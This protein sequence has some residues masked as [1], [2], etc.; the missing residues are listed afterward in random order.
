M[1]PEPISTVYFINPSHQSVRLYVYPANVARQRLGKNITAATNTHA[2]IEL[3]LDGSFSMRSV[4][5]QRKVGEYFSK[6]L[7]LIPTFALLSRGLWLVPLTSVI[8]HNYWSQSSKP[9]NFFSAIYTCISLVNV[10]F[11][12]ILESHSKLNNLWYNVVK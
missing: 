3:L 6:L 8:F 1:A 2:A 10:S 9:V 5:Y 11:I 4:S 12:I 7:V